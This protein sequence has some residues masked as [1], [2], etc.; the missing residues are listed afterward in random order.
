MK[1]KTPSIAGCV[2]WSRAEV[3]YGWRDGTG[4]A[5]HIE[6]ALTVEEGV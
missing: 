5:V 4:L 3:A 2:S 1:G 6:V